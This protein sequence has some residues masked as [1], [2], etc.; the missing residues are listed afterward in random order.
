MSHKLSIITINRNNAD[1]LRKTIES[2]VHQSFKNFEF[3][4]IDG[5]STDGSVD[6]IKEYSEGISF[7][8]SEFDS[9]VYNA[10]NKG[11]TRATGE[12][13]LFLNSGDWLIDEKI[14]E[15]FCNLDVDYDFVYGDLYLWNNGI[16]TPRK[17]S[18]SEDIGY[19]EFYIDS[20]L[21]HQATFIKRAIFSTF[22]LYNE[23]NLYVSDWELFFVAIVVHNSSFQHIDRVISYYDMTGLT[24][25]NESQIK[26][27]EERNLVLNHY[28][29]L[30]NR[31]FFKIL[32][33]NQILR[34]KENIYSEY[35]SLKNGR[36]SLIVR[37]ML[38]L[39]RKVNKLGF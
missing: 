10:M 24:A 39:K 9:G 27:N 21:P 30:V 11:I 2:V 8:V 32:K 4:V 28:L 19:L 22:G 25:R 7:W 1:G 23:T 36:L 26:L 34:S 17:F 6:V 14:V 15:Y 16:V 33:Q 38:W 31:S 20:G 29:P 35:L 18:N 5:N 37:I 3:I 12:Y 13:C